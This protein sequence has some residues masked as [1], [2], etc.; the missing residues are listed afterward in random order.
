MLDAK[1]KLQLNTPA[2]AIPLLG[3]YRYKGAR[4]GRGSGKSHFFAEE[5]VATCAAYP[6]TSAVCIRETQKS[7]KDSAKRLI[8][9]KIVALGVS[10]LFE[11]TQAEIRHKNGDGIIIFTGMQSHN[12][13]S[14]KSLEG[15]KIAWVEEAQS[16]SERSL[17]LLRPT[18]RAAGSQ[19]WFSWNPED[20]EDPVELLFKDA[21][22]DPNMAVVHVNYNQNPYFGAEMIEEME[23]D[24]RIY[25]LKMWNHIWLGEYL[26]GDMGEVFKWN[27]FNPYELTPDREPDMTVMSCDTAAKK[28]EHNDPTC[29]T[30]WEQYGDNVYLV[31]V[32]NE[33]MEYPEL[34]KKVKLTALRYHVDHILIEDASTGQALIPELRNDGLPVVAILTRGQDKIARAS[35]C[36]DKIE[37]GFVYVPQ[38]APWLHDYKKQ[39]TKFSFDKELQKKNHDDMVDSTSQFI[40]WWKTSHTAGWTK[41]LEREYGL[42]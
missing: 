1:G 20:A 42:S 21:D 14:I 19:L 13:D 31:N 8:E 6:D 16:I 15:F 18:I 34:K 3:K 4:G 36:T 32:I 30:V 7:L 28:Q 26:S 41:E 25:P 10:H 33:R 37:S 23:R 17:R 35:S 24:R 22:D 40:N 12:A 11:I 29:I 9:Q 5:L 39:L 27:W 2:W 38:Q